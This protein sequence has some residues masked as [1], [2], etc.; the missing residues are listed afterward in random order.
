[1]LLFDT[2]VPGKVDVGAY[3]N[4]FNPAHILYVSVLNQ[5]PAIQGLSFL[6][7]IVFICHCRAFWSTGI[8]CG[9]MCWR[10]YSDKYLITFYAIWS[11][12]ESVA[13]RFRDTYTFIICW[14]HQQPKWSTKNS[15]KGQLYHHGID[16]LIATT[17][18]AVS[19]KKGK[20]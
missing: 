6:V 10:P 7:L 17:F 15:T 4:M 2:T 19:M 16:A 18:F 20:K 11:L 1:M 14:A 5:K 12:V 13:N 9:V 3:V 8:L